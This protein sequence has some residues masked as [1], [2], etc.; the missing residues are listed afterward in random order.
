[1]SYKLLAFTLL[2][3][4]CS[5]SKKNEP[6]PYQPPGNDSQYE[7]FNPLPEG[8]NGIA[9]RYPGDFGIG[10]DAAVILADDF[11]SYAGAFGLT[12]KWSDA[13]HA[14]NLRIASE[15]GNFFSGKKG[16]EFKVPQTNNEV[17]N[18]IIKQISPEQDSM[19][20]RYYAKFDSSFNVEGSS[21]NGCTMSSSYWNGPGSGPG[22]KA[23][24]FNKFFVSY[25]AGR[26]ETVIA[27]PGQLN[28]YIYHPGQRDIWGDHFYPTGRILPFDQKPGDFGPQFVARP[29]IVPALGRWYCYELMVKPN[30]PGKRNGRIAM[31]LDGKLIADF[32]NLSL[33]ANYDL[34]IDRISI[35]LH[36]KNNTRGEARKWIDNVVAAKSY[37]GPVHR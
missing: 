13:Y 24:G 14:G 6:P 27:N 12:G 34:K 9:S 30:A 22:I 26:F 5:S 10:S 16:L 4:S 32:Q 37:I 18:E 15:S 28:I 17:S 19:F 1:M 23:D 3:F 25:E 21:H 33:R 36:V 35:D 20:L 31:W 8:D 7:H 2:L 29:D 11:E